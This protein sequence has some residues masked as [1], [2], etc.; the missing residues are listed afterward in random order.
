M[1]K[2]V[3]VFYPF[4]FRQYDWNRFEFDK[5]SQDTNIIIFE[6]INYL[7]PHF[8][9]AYAKEKKN[10]NKIIKFKN[11]KQFKKN[12]NLSIKEYSKEDIL[13]LNFMKNDSIK[14]FLINLIIKKFSIKTLSFFN[15]GISNFNSSVLNQE[16]NLLKKFFFLI[17]RRKETLRKIISRFTLY[18]E[19]IF[20]LYPDYILVGGKKCKNKITNKVLKNKI[21]LLMGNSWDYSK[22]LIDKKKIHYLKFKYALYLDAPGP[23]FISDSHLNKEKITETVGHTYPALCN[24]FKYLEKKK[25]IKVVIAPHPKTKIRDRSNLFNKRRVISG[26]T[27]DLIRNAEF[28]ITR[29]STAITYAAY[30]QKPILLIYTDEMYN[31]QAYRNAVPIAKS[32]NTELINIDNLEKLNIKKALRIDRNKYKKYLNNFCTF[33]KTKKPNYVLIKELLI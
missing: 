26:K 22:I 1:K 12:L 17:K 10:N 13:F 11:I 20:N 33:K 28:I 5:L 3:I 21:N 8:N 27:H 4:K 6:F 18:F 29:N 24:F 32:L 30:Y 2:I 31:S 25:N 23:K 14:S 15:P 7:Y 19:E 9:S 16:Y